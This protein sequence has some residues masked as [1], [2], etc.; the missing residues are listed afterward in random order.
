[1][2]LTKLSVKACRTFGLS[3]SVGFK[4]LASPGVPLL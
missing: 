4:R 1:M 3:G 2:T